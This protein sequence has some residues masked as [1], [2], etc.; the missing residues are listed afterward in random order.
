M[1]ILALGAQ[2][3]ERPTVTGTLRLDKD[4]GGGYRYAV[5][6]EDAKLTR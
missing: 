4:F 5:L 1:T 2:R 3:G 6:V